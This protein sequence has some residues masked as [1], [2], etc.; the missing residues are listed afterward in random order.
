M[1]ITIEALTKSSGKIEFITSTPKEAFEIA[2]I[3]DTSDRIIG[4]NMRYHTLE[5][6][7]WSGGKSWKKYKTAFTESDYDQLF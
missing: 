4:W 3:L 6:F 7:G 2:M 1:F 5:D